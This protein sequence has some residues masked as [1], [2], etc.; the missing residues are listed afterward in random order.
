VLH[1][2]KRK[3][4]REGDWGVRSE[5]RTASKGWEKDGGT[6]PICLWGEHQNVKTNKEGGNGRSWDF[7]GKNRK[8]GACPGRKP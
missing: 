8:G 1:T 6:L 3:K 4:K 5:R 7:L 2:R